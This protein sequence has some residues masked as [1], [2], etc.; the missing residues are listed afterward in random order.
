MIVIAHN[1]VH[2]LD[3]RPREPAQQRAH[4]A[5]QADGRDLV[6]ELTDIVAAEYRLPKA[7]PSDATG[8]AAA[9][10]PGSARQGS[11]RIDGVG[12]SSTRG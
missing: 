12:S 5:R 9:D 6:E 1:Y 2:V 8:Y 4:H 7:P 10:R 3:V 11:G